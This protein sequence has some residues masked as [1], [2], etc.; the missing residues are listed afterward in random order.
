MGVCGMTY[1]QETYGY[2][3]ALLSGLRH[4]VVLVHFPELREYHEGREATAHQ[5]EC[6][7]CDQVLEAYGYLMKEAALRA[8]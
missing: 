8:A 1:M 3:D 4:T 5:R 2:P 7:T 6:V